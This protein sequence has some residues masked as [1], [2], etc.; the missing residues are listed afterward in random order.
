[1]RFALLGIPA[2]SLNEHISDPAPAS[3]AALKGGR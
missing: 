2:I 1:M 3:T